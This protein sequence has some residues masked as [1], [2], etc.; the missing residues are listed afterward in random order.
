MKIV[1]PGGSGLIGT[2]L[3]D[4]FCESGDDVVVLS[5]CPQM[6]NWKSVKWDGKSLGNWQHEID[7]ADIVINLAGSS[8]NCRYNKR[9]RDEIMNSRIDSTR[10]I[11]EAIQ[12]AQNPPKIWLQSS[13]ATIYSH[14]YDDAND[15]ATGIL[16]GEEVNVPETWRFS[17]DVAKKWEQ[18]AKEVEVPGTRKVFMR[19]AVVMHPEAN[20][21]F[22]ILYVMVRRGLGGKNG[23][24]RQYVSW[25][26]GHDFL[27]A[28][29]FLIDHPLEG[30]INIAA[31]NPLPNREFMQHFRE[32][33][34]VKLGLPATN[35]MLELAAILLRTETELI[36]KSR[37][38]VPGKLQN[39]GF[40]FQYPEWKSAV[41]DLVQ[42]AG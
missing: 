30:P 22:N 34:G 18:A 3:A 39:A 2:L 4:S 41:R 10:V 1:I 15:E 35:R 14:R 32:A 25:I 16:G 8:V 38:V 29:R 6:G 9:N 27:Q 24:G 26:H 11:G 31:P 19:T 33:V 23:D 7:G 36:L 12:Q 21:A 42:F 13:T 20:S 5:R 37:R 40:E 28:V 17:I